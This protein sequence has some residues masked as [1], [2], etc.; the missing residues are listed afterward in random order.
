M[1]L[2]RYVPLEEWVLEM[3][4]VGKGCGAASLVWLKFGH[5]ISDRLASFVKSPV[6]GS[7]SAR[8]GAMNS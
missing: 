8:V 7:D 1:R 6:R 5:A 2:L 3:E 4:R